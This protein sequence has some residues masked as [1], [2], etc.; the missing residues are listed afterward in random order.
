MMFTEM[1]WP[2]CPELGVTEE[3]LAEGF[4]D[5]AAVFPLENVVP[6]D[7]IPATDTV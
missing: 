7:E 1:V 4:T 6:S 2:T 3:M 5:N